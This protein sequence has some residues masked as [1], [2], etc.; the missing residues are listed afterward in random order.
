MG[1]L[2]ATKLA[3]NTY[4]DV[5]QDKS[6]RH[7]EDQAEDRNISNTSITPAHLPH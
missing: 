5:T 7:D 3:D 6:R 4:D 2:R 1:K